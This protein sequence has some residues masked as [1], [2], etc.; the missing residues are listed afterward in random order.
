MEKPMSTIWTAGPQEA[1]RCTETVLMQF[2]IFGRRPHTGIG[3][4]GAL[5]ENGWTYRP[6]EVDGAEYRGTV[7]RF[8]R[9][10]PTGRYYVATSGHAMAV[11][12]GVLVDSAERGPD[13]R[14]VIGAFEVYPA[15]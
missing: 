12:D 3:V 5:M 6:V 4:L 9:E 2:G 13:G 14:R 15:A 10:H 8:C 1:R 11:I 7:R